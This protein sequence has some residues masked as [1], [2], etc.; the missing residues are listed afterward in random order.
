MI[1]FPNGN[2]LSF[3]TAMQ[4]R[5]FYVLDSTLSAVAAKIESLSLPSLA[6]DNDI[7]PNLADVDHSSFVL[8]P[9]SNGALTV[10][11]GDSEAGWMLALR[12]FEG[13]YP[14]FQVTN[15]DGAQ[16]ITSDPYGFSS[17]PWDGV[18]IEWNLLGFSPQR[19]RGMAFRD[20]ICSGEPYTSPSGNDLVLTS[21]TIMIDVFSAATGADSVV[22]SHISIL[23]SFP[24]YL[25]V[26]GD[27]FGDEQSFIQAC[28]TPEGH[29]SVGGDCFDGDAT[30]YPNAPGTQ[31]GIDNNCDGQLNGDEP[32]LCYGDVEI[33]GDINVNDIL[34]LLS[35]VGCNGFC[36]SQDLDFDGNV[37]VNDMLVVLAAFGSN[38]N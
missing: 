1:R 35:N 13:S 12:P 19:V 8:T 4:F 15:A 23:N 2:Q 37:G 32:T 16:R 21:D 38:C 14:V 28:E 9:E 10:S 22:F 18:A 25:D 33:D 24:S 3:G 11:K 27:G 29:S 36:G 26:D 5:Y 20:T 6:F 34:S 31:H 17:K 30:V 7:L